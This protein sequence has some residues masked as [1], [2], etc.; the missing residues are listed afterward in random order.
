MR[1]PLTLFAAS[2]LFGAAAA[3]ANKAG[4][5]PASAFLSGEVL[6]KPNDAIEIQRCAGAGRPEDFRVQAFKVGREL[7]LTVD[8]AARAA[9]LYIGRCSVA[10]IPGTAPR[11]GGPTYDP[12]K[13]EAISGAAARTAQLLNEQRG[14]EEIF[15]GEVAGRGPGGRIDYQAL[16]AAPGFQPYA[17]GKRT[18][19][20]PEI[21]LHSLGDSSVAPAPT[22]LAR[23]RSLVTPSAKTV[24]E[25][26]KTL[27]AKL[28]DFELPPGAAGLASSDAP[29]AEFV[30]WAKTA[31][32]S[33]LP[34]I[35]YGILKEGEVG[36]Y[37]V[38][39]LGGPGTITLNH[40]IR[41]KPA[42]ERSAVLF[43]ELYHYWDNKVARLH[44]ANVS[45]GYIDPAHAPEHEYDAYYMTALY[46]QKIKGANSSSA[47]A[48]CLDRYPTE[49][50]RVR[51][52]VDGIVGG[53]R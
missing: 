19:R 39:K 10:A 32:A 23:A 15:S 28:A 4:T 37:A 17:R 30:Q 48:R 21:D 18:G 12:R 38:G 43:H 40:Y 50:E 7:G 51:A 42:D 49:P 41:D 3:A 27:K 33:S 34:E 1:V 20:V 52:V 16:N 5:T 24:A 14:L 25:D 44:Y 13:S 53:K 45:Y 11:G 9:E 31:P 2:L 46:W 22:L 47:L 36:D 8:E 26:L 35:T 6:A 29:L